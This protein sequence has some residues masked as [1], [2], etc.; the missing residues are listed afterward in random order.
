M[1]VWRVSDLCWEGFLSLEW[2][3]HLRISSIRTERS[4]E[5]IIWILLYKMVL[6]VN[7]MLGMSHPPSLF[8]RWRVVMGTLKIAP[9]HM[10]QVQI[11]VSCR[12]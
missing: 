11:A 6:H 5:P 4:L 10:N 1:V 9:F 7:S 8:G 2:R 3:S 12:A